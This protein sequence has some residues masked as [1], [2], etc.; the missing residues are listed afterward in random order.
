MISS[1]L[2]LRAASPLLMG[3]ALL[4]WG[5][6]CSLLPYALVMALLVETTQLISWRWSISDKEFN[7]LSDFSGVMFFIAVLYIFSDEGAQGI[8]VILKI[9]PFILFPLLIVQKYSAHGSMKSS[10]LFVS[11]RKLDP[12][13]S[14]E[15]NTRID[16]SLPYFVCCIVS[17]SAGNQRTIWFFVLVCFL[18]SCVLWNIRPKRY[19]TPVWILMIALTFSIAYAGQFGLRQLQASIEATFLGVFDQFMWRYRDPNRA[20]TTIGSLGRLKLS[21]RIVLRLRTDSKLQLPFL[22]REAS[23]NTFSHGIWSSKDSDFVVIDQN[24]DNSWTLADA[25]N[26][27]ASVT[28][29]TYMVREKGVIP[30]PH[31]STKLENVAAIEI[32]KNPKGTVLMDIREGWIQYQAQFQNDNLHELS[33]DE[34]DLHVNKYYQEDFV[35]LAKELELSTMTS[36][37]AVYTVQQFFQNNFKYSLNQQQRYPKGKYLS[38]FLFNNRQGHCEYFAT[39]TVLLLRSAGIPARYAVGYSVDEYS[40]LEGQ[41]V[42]RARHA[43]SWALVYIDNEWQVLDTT[44][45][46]WAPYEDENT[47]A[48][49]P[50][51]DLWAWVSYT[52]SRW[53]SEDAAEEEENT[54]FLL[55]LLIPLISILAWRMYFKERIQNNKSTPNLENHSEVAGTDSCFYLLIEQIEQFGLRRNTGE[56]L[57]VWFKRIENKIQVRQLHSALQLHYQYRFDPEGLN[58]DDTLELKRLVTGLLAARNEWII[59]DDTN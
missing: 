32:E 18:I 22:L 23:Y 58:S 56:T 46:V 13:L 19:A 15:A 20:T 27:D 29:S 11:L 16:V 59:I 34:N 53:Q 41:Y 47:S 1:T 7:T 54:G 42:A 12:A 6:Q 4:L 31:G 9:L 24:L 51:M 45:S 52:W 33:P 14:P 5:W 35:R 57:F 3:S 28:L 2:Q 38:N 40:S 55:W 48:I 49:E 21:D 26:S 43:H 36:S 39:A 17:A 37:Q 8:F 50:L 10:A 25:K 44:P 30:L